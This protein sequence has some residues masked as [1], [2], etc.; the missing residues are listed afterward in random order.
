[1]M[2]VALILVGYILG[3]IPTGYITVRWMTGKDVRTIQSG[4]TGGT[5]AMR[6][7]GLK[8]GLITAFGDISKAIVA[9]WLARLIYPGVPLLHVAVGLA[10]VIGHNYSLF[11]IERKDGGLVFSGGAGGAP[12]VGAAVGLWAPIG[13]IMIPV[14]ALILY[15]IGY[16][17]VTT[18]TAGVTA[19]IVFLLR[20][21]AG[22]DPMVYLLFG[23]CAELLLLWSLRP[24]IK[25][26]LAGEERLV[27]LRAQKLKE[28]EA[29]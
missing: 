5:N 19:T 17:S 23:L 26:L 8:A 28:Q 13:L 6:V 10:A 20:G 25:R 16:A 29:V 9:V 3:S 15:L 21:L 12:T 2:M 22:V 24:N 27:G 4:R 11:L 18:M 14:G 7:A 1:M